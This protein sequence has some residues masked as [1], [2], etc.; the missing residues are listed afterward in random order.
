MRVSRPLAALAALAAAAASLAAAP[1]STDATATATGD[2]VTVTGSLAE[3]LAPVVL[4]TDAVGDA[5]VTET[6]ADLT[7]LSVSFPA[8]GKVA[9]HLA[10][11][12]NPAT[13]FQ[14]YGIQYSTVVD[15]GSTSLE[16]I[17]N[18]LP[19]GLTFASQTCVEG[20]AS[21][22]CTSSPVQGG[23]ANGVLT[24]TFDLPALPGAPVV[25]SGAQSNPQAN[26]GGAT[27]TFTGGL[28]DQ[29]SAS[30]VGRVPSATLLIDG[31][32]TT[33]GA[34]NGTFALSASGV[35]PGERAVS[36][37]LCGADPEVACTVLDLGT[38]TVG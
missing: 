16:L 25:S 6:G 5:L 24:W 8:P 20:P 3:A 19:T 10:I 23:Y 4:G 35:A 2:T 31:V 22:E 12:P 1:S 32:P 14:P 18:G 37:E 36:V 27:L 13:G 34:L 38:V 17:A 7:G 28:Y 26:A 33:T 9:A 15:L 29:L 11:D 30:A 21:Q